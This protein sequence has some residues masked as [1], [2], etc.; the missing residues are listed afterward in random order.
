MERMSLGERTQSPA[1]REA[2][3]AVFC[4]ALPG[5]VRIGTLPLVT[6]LRGALGDNPEVFT[7]SDGDGLV[8]I[9]LTGPS[10]AASVSK[11]LK[12]ALSGASS[13]S[14]GGV[15]ISAGPGMISGSSQRAPL[16]SSRRPSSTR[17]CSMSGPGR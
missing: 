9:S 10:P 12:E 5:F 11:S 6:A 3:R 14:A 2:Q 17:E 1:L 15:R 8:T 16:T 7:G 4:M 13:G